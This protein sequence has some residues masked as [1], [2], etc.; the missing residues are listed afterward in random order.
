MQQES[1]T[2]SS[3]LLHQAWP[4]LLREGRCVSGYKPCG[5]HDLCLFMLGSEASSRTLV[6]SSISFGGGGGGGNNNDE[7]ISL[8][9][10][11]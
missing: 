3:P 5:L 10:L 4:H 2:A 11:E 6:L 7:V 8:A 1:P 9:T